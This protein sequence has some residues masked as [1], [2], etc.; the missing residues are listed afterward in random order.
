MEL[1]NLKNYWFIIRPR[2]KDFIILFD[3]KTKDL[4]FRP[5]LKDTVEATVYFTKP[6]SKVFYIAH[7]RLGNVGN[8]YKDCNDDHICILSI[9]VQK[10]M[11]PH[12]TINVFGIASESGDLLKGHFTLEFEEQSENQV[13]NFHFK[14]NR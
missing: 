8:N 4:I 7:N 2:S 9:K 12:V 11:L 13:S 14:I 1:Y 10:N 6:L 3:H 5:K